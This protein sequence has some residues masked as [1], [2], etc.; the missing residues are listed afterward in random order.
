M[1]QRSSAG[2]VQSKCA[3]R[4]ICAADSV[5]GLVQA[6]VPVHMYHAAH[7]LCRLSSASA[8]LHQE[9]AEGRQEAL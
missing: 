2:Q 3:A 9:C 7:Q 4:C 8:S 1:V 6:E 5:T